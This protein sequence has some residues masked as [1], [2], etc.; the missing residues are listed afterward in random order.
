MSDVE[1]IEI[2]M[3]QAKA[4]IEKRRALGRLQTNP[5]F[6]Q[7]ILDGYMKDHAIHLV[8]LKAS[9]G[10]QGPKDQAY[11]ENQINAIGHLDQYLSYVDQTGRVAAETLEAD[12]KERAR[13]LEE[14]A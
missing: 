2:S 6:K 5:D 10:A 8:L 14:E 12:E 1:T 13:I 11:I 7:L 4:Q 9:M 3:E